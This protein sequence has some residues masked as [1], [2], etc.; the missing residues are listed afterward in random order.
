MKFR[1][2]FRPF[3]SDSHPIQPISLPLR[4]YLQSGVKRQGHIR[5]RFV[6]ANASVPPVVEIVLVACADVPT[7][8]VPPLGTV[9]ALEAAGLVVGG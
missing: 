1:H 8:V 7:V 4:N 6:A 9:S 3:P 5:C 2:P